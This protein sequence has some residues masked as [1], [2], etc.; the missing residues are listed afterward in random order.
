MLKNELFPQSDVKMLW[1]KFWPRMSLSTSSF[2]LSWLVCQQQHVAATTMLD[3]P[4][5][6]SF[7][8][9]AWPSHQRLH[10]LFRQTTG[11]CFSWSNWWTEA[12]MVVF[13]QVSPLPAVE[14]CISENDH[15]FLGFFHYWGSSQTDYSDYTADSRSPSGFKLLPLTNNG[16][17][18]HWDLSTSRDV[19]WFSSRFK[20]QNNLADKSLEFTLGVWP[21]TY[22]V[23]CGTLQRWM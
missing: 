2:P 8:H 23:N 12:E 18:A 6:V 19:S 15:C 3:E 17:C 16:G 10:S 20:P 13:L 5:L 14:R 21:L 1:S 11:S 7:K 9:D 4:C 22:A